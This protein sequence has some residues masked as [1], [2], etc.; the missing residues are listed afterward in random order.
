[1]STRGPSPRLGK[2]QWQIAVFTQGK[3][4]GW[5][6]WRTFQERT[7]SSRTR[8]QECPQGALTVQFCWNRNLEV[9]KGEMRLGWG[10]GGG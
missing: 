9:E 7:V 1:M 2:R 6:M 8:R 3:G 5:E 10:G 4:G